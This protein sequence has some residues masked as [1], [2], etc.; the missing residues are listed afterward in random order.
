MAVYPPAI[1]IGVAAAGGARTQRPNRR[2]NMPDTPTLICPKCRGEMRTYER[3]SV[4]VDQCEECRGIFLDRG[5][6]E[7][8]LDAERGHERRD[9]HDHERR[10][11]H[12]HEHDH[13][14]E[15]KGRGSRR[16]RAS[17]FISD[18]LGGGE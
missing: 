16:T 10:D 14:Y 7:R 1:T 4:L 12:D 15:R 9:E 5:E 11:E 17:T 13:E 6:L 2:T 18:F 8:L 3:N